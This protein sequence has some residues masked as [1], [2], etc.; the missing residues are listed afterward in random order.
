MFEGSGVKLQSHSGCTRAEV[1]RDVIS[2]PRLVYIG[3]G[4]GRWGVDQAHATS[5]PGSHGTMA[6]S[7]RASPSKKAWTPIPR[8]RRQP[9]WCRVG[10]PEG[11]L[12]P[13]EVPARPC[14]FGFS[15]HRPICTRSPGS[16]FVSTI[17]SLLL[18]GSPF[19]F[20]YALPHGSPQDAGRP[21]QANDCPTVTVG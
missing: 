21:P 10:G 2:G 8:R 6:R 17:A 14:R 15:L 20:Q 13:L 9:A 1:E 4:R 18:V 7:T 11:S 16:P 12:G 5:T 3:P 19:I